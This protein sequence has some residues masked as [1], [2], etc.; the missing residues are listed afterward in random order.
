MLQLH[1]GTYT[2]NSSPIGIL[3]FTSYITP[4]KFMTILILDK[5]N[6]QKFLSVRNIYRTVYNFSVAIK[7]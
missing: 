5:K 7:F 4:K 6:D 1:F 3:T 2:K